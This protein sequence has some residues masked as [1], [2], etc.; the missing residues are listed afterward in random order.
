VALTA[1]FAGAADPGRPAIFAVSQTIAQTN[2]PGFGAEYVHQQR[3]NNWTANPG[4]EPLHHAMY[5][6]INGGGADAT[7]IY[8]VCNTRWYDTID[9]G[10]FNGGHYRL[11]REVTNAAGQG[12]I[13]KLR[14]GT[15]APGGYIAAGW[16]EIDVNGMNAY[17]PATTAADAF[18]MRNGETWYY[19]I[20][21]RDTAGG[22]SDY[23]PAVMVT[24]Q[25]GLTNG[26]RITT[27]SVPNPTLGRAYTVSSPLLTFR[28]PGGV[29]F[30]SWN[31][32][33]GAL[34]A[35][36]SMTTTGI[37]V[38]TCNVNAEAQ[39][40]V[41]A[42]DTL[43]RTNARTYIVFRQRPPGTPAAPAPPSNLTAEANDG[44]VYLTWDA[45]PDTDVDYYRIYRSR[46]HPNDHRTCVYLG[47]GGVMP[48]AN[49]LLFIGKEWPGY[50]AEE[51]RSTRVAGLH[52]LTGWSTTGTDVNQDMA[53]HPLPLPPALAAEY[54]G[55]TCLRLA[56]PASGEFGI[57]H[58]KTGAT[59]D[60]WWSVS[61]LPT[62]KTYRMECWAYAA[63]L[64]SNTVRF[65]YA[66]YIDRT[67]TGLVNGAWVKLGVTFA[68]SNWVNNSQSVFGPYFYFRGPGTVYVDNAVLY[69]LDEPR[70]ACGFTD[71][72][73]R[74]LWQPYLGT[75]ATPAKGV[76]RARYMQESFKHIMNPSMMSMRGWTV[77]NG[78]QNE[79][80]LHI[81]DAL[82]ASYESGATPATR[83]IPWIT[84]NLNW[85][86]QDFVDLMEYLAGPAGTPYGD[87]R[88]AMRGGIAA[89]WTN[90]F[91]SVIIEMGNEPWN[92]GY[93]FAFRGGFS[94]ASGRTYGRWCNYIWNHVASNSP[95]YA[96]SNVRIS[97]G[98]W[99][100]ALSP[101]AFTSVART[102]C[103]QADLIGLTSYLGGWEAGQEGQI[104]GTT[105]SDE[106][107]QQWMVYND[108]SGLGYVTN[109]V[110]MQ[111]R[112]AAQGLPFDVVMYEG[113]PSY[114]MN[115]LNNVSL[116]P[117]EQ[118]VSRNYGRTL[119][120][121]IGTL[122]FWLYA[123]YCGIKEQAFFTF[124][125][126][127][128]LWC[129]HTHVWSGY[130]P[131]PAWQAL[132]LINTH[133][134]GA[135]MLVCAAQSV[136][137][138]DLVYLKDGVTVRKPDMTLAAVY[139]FQRG[140][141]FIVVAINKK[142]DGVH[143][144]DD[145]GDGSTPLTLH[146]P[147]S[148][149]SSIWLHKLEGDPRLTNR[150]AFNFQ[151]TSQQIA[152]A[153]FSPS[154]VVNQNTGGRTNGLPPGAVY[155]YCFANCTPDALPVRPQVT[156]SQAP[157]QNDPADGSA[158]NEVNFIALFDRV[159]TGFF[160]QSSDV[161]I[162]GSAL[163]QTVAV[164][165]VYGSQGAAYELLIS[166][167]QRDGIVSVT[168]PADAAIDPATGVGNDPSTAFDNTVT[169][170]YSE[171]IALLEWEFG[172]PPD[173][174]QPNPTSRFNHAFVAPGVIVGGP[175]VQVS[176][177]RHYNGDAF[178][179]T[180]VHSPQFDINDYLAWRVVPLS[181]WLVSL[182]AVTFGTFTQ[183]VGDDYW[184]E[185]RVSTNAFA[186]SQ[187]VALS[188][189]NPL[190]GRGLGSTAGTLVSAG[191][192]NIALLQNCPVPVEF[193][194]YLWGVT[195]QYNGAGIGKLGDT[196]PDLLIKGSV[197]A[198]GAPIIFS[199]PAS[200]A[201]F[202][203]DTVTFSVV[204]DGAQP[205]FYQWRKDGADIA[206]AT[207]DT[208][209]I[210]PLTTNDAG[211]YCALVSNAFGAAL[212]AEAQLVV[213]PEP[214][215]PLALIVCAAA[216]RRR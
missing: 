200:V 94:D 170:T 54:P 160:D 6:E 99:A 75:P 9:S 46:Q 117:E 26:P 53:P 76:L 157:A 151:V 11:Y 40:T 183:V 57:W 156:I 192:S 191:L 175:G 56:A 125:Q 139:A 18:R 168:I 16:M 155:V 141:D 152:L 147:F 174:V 32:I 103:P 68:V 102:E 69:C 60:S 198:A 161:A 108:R 158:R 28:A 73:Y 133:A 193:R 83:T 51:T 29:G 4:M 93:F 17:P 50:P 172:S 12:W 177:N 109:I 118:E 142:L 85:H 47:S 145:F 136:P 100:G 167:M 163:P 37:V 62:G 211:W 70:G 86:E 204:A 115:G 180:Y 110:A 185:L 79:D 215:A 3:I 127:Q 7:G 124:S 173:G 120:A 38:G 2:P 41:R 97:L 45:P 21:T 159:V 171:G 116:T 186:T 181:N 190:I 35:G 135:R 122:D 67:L 33:A 84:A 196:E 189:T 148:A 55:E 114:L 140:T 154:F 74:E 182:Y 197:Q 113:G 61:Q 216:W 98:G 59:N 27:Q 13:Q 19:T 169:I 111:Q 88:I 78:A 63:G 210:G 162:G 1:L 10:F 90:E 144:G 89:P 143:D 129:S 14:E 42:T 31:I 132:Q 34:P 153:Q 166:G 199:P 104:G 101:N 25:A 137:T 5:W 146:L 112:M 58:F 77:N 66:N 178:G 24:P 43:G 36:L 52:G 81:H 95:H 201:R 187:L 179:V 91:R 23:A 30:T 138:F 176:E 96:D 203:H 150:D 65:R 8:A 184:L 130:R 48:Q 49:D 209:I 106:G 82:Q 121:G 123:T 164:K 134:G 15:I 202:P 44:L 194:L 126:D 119:A 195:G 22:W 64:A 205:L 214:Y 208:C 87:L 71:A 128:G 131:H 213:L 92:S 212:S 149:P 105:W 206:H 39:F 80:P 207:N 72:I 188:V 20:R 107:V 165:P